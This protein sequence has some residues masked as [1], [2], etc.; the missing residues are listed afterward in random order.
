M[1]TMQRIAKKNGLKLKSR[2]DDPRK[3]KGHG[4]KLR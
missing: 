2:D 1:Y 3:F 4:F